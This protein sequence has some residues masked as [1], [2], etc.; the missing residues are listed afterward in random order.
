[1]PA[2]LPDTIFAL[3][4]GHGRAGIAVVR[5]SGP[6]A[7][8]CLAEL[9]GSVPPLRQAALR[10]LKATDR[11]VIDE[12]MVLYFAAPHS[13]TGEDVAEL[14]VHGAPAV[15]EALLAELGAKPGL[16][17]AE[18]GEFTRRAF[19]ND[20]MDLVEVEGLADLLGA[21]TEVQR[22]LA[23]R[24]FL[25]DAS[26]VY[27]TW[28]NSV[29]SALSLFEA[30]IDFSG[31]DDV[32][33]KAQAAAW[34]KI[35]G[36]VSELENALAQADQFGAIRSGL[37][38]VIAG[39][40]N[41]GKS[42]LLNALAGREVAIVSPIAGTTR[43]IVESHLQMVGLPLIL[44]DTAGLRE[45]ASDVIEDEGMARAKAASDSADILIWVT[46]ADVSEKVGPPRSPDLIVQNK[47]D[48]IPIRNRNE[49]GI[50]VSTL[51]GVGL[52]E[53]RDA[54]RKL[55][56]RRV[57]GAEHAVV[58][59]QRHVLAV[60]ESIRL[61]NN[62]LTQQ[63]RDAELTAEDL[64][65]AARALSSVTGHVDVEDLLGNIFNEFCIGK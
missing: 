7:G 37:R 28:R 63:K 43:D 35:R 59:R 54:L 27:V 26:T 10:K 24:Q 20:K 33:A 6:L 5:L 65:R 9:T 60:K 47:V 55:V 15:V 49:S 11:S 56:E 21:T 40:P 13:V 53:L 42:S 16:R 8:Q 1:M 2:A 51:T 48:L 22:K 29:I 17:I 32:A 58:V 57:A 25:G 18:A 19:A 36:L 45:V 34:P 62:C 46:A 52:V 12:A 4:S 38:V 14:H 39:A 31:E 3:S 41:V 30:S 23:M 50:A 44:A 64:R 61:L